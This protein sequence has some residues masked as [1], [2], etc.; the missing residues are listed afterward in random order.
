VQEFFHRSIQ[1]A[2]ANI[3]QTQVK[4]GAAIWKL[5]NHAFVVR[6]ATATIGFDLTRAHSAG[7]EEFALPDELMTR[8]VRQC[9]ALFVSHYHRDHADEWVARQFLHLDKPVVAPESIWVGTEIHPQIRH[10]SRDADQVHSL[11]VQ[12]GRRALEVVVYPGYQGTRIPNNVTLV[13][14]PEQLSF[15]H[16]GDQSNTESFA[17][18]DKV[19]TRHRVDVL[20]PNCWTTDLIRMIRGMQPRLVITGHENELGHSIDHREANWRT[21]ERLEGSQ[22]PWVLMTW[23]ESYRYSP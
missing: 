16:T 14:T 7:V 8:L 6:T 5:Y 22:A 19:K 20:M 11:P 17:W 18:I 10:L 12:Q 23:G 21:Y 3:E 13:I 2:V 9:D 1:R 15:C 4:Q